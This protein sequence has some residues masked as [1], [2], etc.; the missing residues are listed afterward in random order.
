MAPNK[1]IFTVEPIKVEMVKISYLNTRNSS[2]GLSIPSSRK[3]KSRMNRTPSTSVITTVALPH[4]LLPAEL[5]PYSREPNPRVEKRVPSTS[6]LGEDSL[7]TFRS[8][9]QDKMISSKVSG[10]TMMNRMRQ[11]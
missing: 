5:K 2:I 11:V 7:D 4:P 8:Q 3:T 1:V 9:S 10:M 6:N